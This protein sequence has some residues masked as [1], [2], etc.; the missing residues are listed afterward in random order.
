MEINRVLFQRE[1]GGRAA[2][3]YKHWPNYDMARIGQKLKDIG[4]TIE[5]N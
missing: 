5:A 2:E 4:K 1:L 3:L